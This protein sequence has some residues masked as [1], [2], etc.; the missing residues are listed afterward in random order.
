M[1]GPLDVLGVPGEINLDYAASA[2]C[3]RAAADAV[4]G[5]LPWYA[6]VHR[7]AGALSAHCTLAYERARQTIGD[8]FGART[9][10]HVIVTRNTTDAL[11][12]L[13]RALPA[14]TTV[15]TFAG[16]HH[17]NLLPWPTGTVRLPVPDSPAAAVRTLD[18]A[19]RELRRG[20]A[21]RA[22]DRPVLVAVTGASNVTG[23]CWPVAALAR[24]AHR[25]GARIVVD[26]AQLAPHV[27]VDLAALDVDYLA[28]SGHKLYAPFGAG[29]LIGR[30]DWLDAAPPYLAG[31][32]ATGHVGDATHDVRWATGPGRHEA[33]TPNLLGTVALAAV[34]TA[35]AEADRAALH[36]REQALLTRLRTGLAALPE[37]VDLRTFG[38]DAERVGI[39]SFVVAGRDSAEIAATLAREHRIGVRD[40]LFCA[41]PLARR[42]LAEAAAR[43]GRRD[44]P[45]TA[46]RVSFGLGSTAD[47]VDRLLDALAAIVR[48]SGP[49]RRQP[50]P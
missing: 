38:A 11:N 49:A 48:P 3:L 37:V 47:Q 43:T 40:G 6:S 28:V 33:G 24:Q 21:G 44:L 31:G 12:L 50:A 23:E 45:P 22:T 42:L 41:H 2:P 9:D 34:C 15:V 10:D 32:G 25:H 17:A 7:G 46:L 30:A 14:G 39:V 8:F 13:A 20:P 19:L 27:P 18:A 35:L 4:T 16:E 36:A 5:L 1:T 29:V 26:A